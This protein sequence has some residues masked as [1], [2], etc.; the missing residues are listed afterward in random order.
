MIDEHDVREMLRHRANA[1]DS[2]VVD[3]PRAARRARRRLLTNGVVMMVLAAAVAVTALVGVDAIR[4]AP[5][6]VDRPTPTGPILRS[7]DEVLWFHASRGHSG[8]LVGVDP[9][10]GEERMIA[11]DTGYLQDATWSADGRWVA[12]ETLDE[13]A[14]SLWVVDAELEPR[15]VIDLTEELVWSHRGPWVWSSTGALLA[16]NRGST[17]QVI[18]PVSGRTTELESA[19]EVTSFPAWSPD[20]TNIAIGATGGS[21]YS[22]DVGTGERSLLVQLPG[23]DLDQVDTIAWSPD[24]SRLAI[25]T[26]LKPG[27]RPGPGRVFVVN[28]DGSDI[29]VLAEGEFVPWF[30]WSPD[31]SRI[32]VSE[33]QGLERSR[34]WIVPADGS[35]MSHVATPDLYSP[36]WGTPAWSPNG[37]RIAF[38]VE[39][40]R[41]FV[42]DAD[43]SGDPT[44]IDDLTYASWSG[45]SFCWDCLWWINHPVNYTDGAG[46]EDGQA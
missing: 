36:S 21:I 2:T 8:D 5:V 6:P 25:L 29:R 28:A 40:N 22:V 39:P 27:P 46:P 4:S 38:S 43:G 41:A 9:T 45:G 17:L 11:P 18:D 12:Y 33:R 42:I 1:A 7:S 14:R 19:V 26:D 15:K 10:T 44:P 31:G 16:V 37:S 24:G 35:A 13:T 30:D 32:V 3:A 34:I 23:N 20:D